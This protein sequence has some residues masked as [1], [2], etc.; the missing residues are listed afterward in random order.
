MKSASDKA[1]LNL[2]PV[3]RDLSLAYALS[4]LVA[5]L[6]TIASAGGL[7][8]PASFYPTDEL[9]RTFAANDVVNLLIG[10]PILSG[11]LWL[12]RRGKLV[13]LLIWPGT[14]LYVFYNYVAYLVGIPFGFITLVYLALVFVS[15]F[16]VFDLA[17]STDGF[18]VQ[19][20]LAGAVSERIAGWVMVVFGVLFILR[21]I[22]MLVQAGLDQITLAVS[23]IG[24]L[25]ADLAIS[26]LWIAGGALLLRREP[27]GYV[28]GLGLLLAASMLF[29]GL[30][31]FLVLQPILTD[32]PF[33]PIDVIVVFGMG[34]ICF[35]PFALFLR[36]VLS[37]ERSI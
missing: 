26:M 24:V 31:M 8:A 21:A 17:K 19:A 15:A 7:L 22:G 35:I 28:A 6:M 9:F 18:S 32:A 10:L 14:L 29:V 23:D 37:R 33:A 36:G 12:A 4:L 5:L 20:R 34:L 11:A 16:V 3:K 27:L 30:I 25:M 13:G 1:R 2:L